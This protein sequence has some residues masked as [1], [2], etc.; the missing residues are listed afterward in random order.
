MTH[1]DD[2]YISN[3]IVVSLN[4]YYDNYDT[5]VSDSGSADYN[6][7]DIYSSDTNYDT[8]PNMFDYDYYENN[9]QYIGK[10]IIG[11]N[12]DVHYTTYFF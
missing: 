10:F 12:F 2:A 4:D 11:Y 7:S 6:D 9:N 1:I 8:Y 3:K 5:Y